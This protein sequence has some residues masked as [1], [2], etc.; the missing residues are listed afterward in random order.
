[1]RLDT[2]G[3]R[4]ARS[5]DAN[6]TSLSV[7]TYR[8]AVWVNSAS[9]PAEFPLLLRVDGEVMT[10]TAVSGSASPQTFTVTRSD[11]SWPHDS[12][13]PVRVAESARW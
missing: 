2:A 8:G 3:S 12:G 10:V 9:N 11:D 1:M 4:L 5:I 7:T 6:T 13:A